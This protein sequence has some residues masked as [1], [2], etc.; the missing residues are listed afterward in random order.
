MYAYL[1]RKTPTYLLE[2]DT[3]RIPEDEEYFREFLNMF[4]RKNSLPS[5]NKSDSDQ[6]LNIIFILHIYSLIISI[7]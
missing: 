4:H 6:R 5:F 7:S 2:I 1:E 3:Y